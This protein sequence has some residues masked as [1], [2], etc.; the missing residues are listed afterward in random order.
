MFRVISKIFLFITLILISIT[1]LNLKVQAEENDNV[2]VYSPEIET[3]TETIYLEISNNYTKQIATE[4]F[5][6]IREKAQA[7]YDELNENNINYSESKAQKESNFTQNSATPSSI[8]SYVE[9]DRV[10]TYN[11]VT[12]NINLKS[13]IKS[14]IGS[15]PTIILTGNHLYSSKTLEGSYSK[16][17]GFDVEWTGS[18]IYVG[19]SHSIDYKVTSSNFWITKG[20][21]VT[22]Y[23]GIG[24]KSTSNQSDPVLTNKKASIY[25]TVY[26][27]HARTYMPRPTQA[28]MSVVPLESRV[29]WD[30]TLRGSYISAYIG[31]YGSPSWD[32]AAYDIH[33]VIPREY[34]GTNQFSNLFPVP[35]TVHQQTINPWWSAY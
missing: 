1:G 17:T 5:E 12:N 29:P 20:T 24:T 4:T 15:T 6:D 32:W 27:S 22:G 33:H 23:A 18:N 14:I 13:T 26:N 8:T 7:S 16:V 11:S 3:I 10:T 31:S 30:N 19:K 21:G 34:G 2:D 9:I 28:N 35:R 25:P